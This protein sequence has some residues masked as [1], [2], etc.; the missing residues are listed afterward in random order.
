MNLEFLRKIVDIDSRSNQ[1]KGVNEV[2]KILG[3]TLSSLGFDAN[4][5]QNNLANTG[6]LLWAQLKGRT[7]RAI[8][9]VCHA[10]TVC[11]PSEK[12]KFKID[13]ANSRAYGPG[14]GDNKGGIALI[15]GALKDF[16]DISRKH[17][18]TINFICSPSE[19]IGSI[20]YHDF[21][22][23]RGIESDFVFGFEPALSNG[24]IITTRSGNRW[25]DIKIS[26]VSA[27]A[28]RWNENSINAAHIASEV[29]ANL[30]KLSSFELKRRVNVAQLFGG[31]DRFNVICGEMNIKLDT[32]FCDF[33]SREYIHE[34]ILKELECTKIIDP[35]NKIESNY[36]FSVA[37][38]CPPMGK[39]EMSDAFSDKILSSIFSFES[40]KVNK[41]YSGGAA[42]INYFQRPGLISIDGLGPVASKLHSNQEFIEIE[43]FYTRRQVFTELLL[44]L[45]NNFQEEKSGEYTLLNSSG[46]AKYSELT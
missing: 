10:D 7:S 41:A 5:L 30:S 45:N 29:V 24:D 21:F 6:E 12:C 33:D 11:G 36:S 3:E 18:Y 23:L 44:N 38:D 37:D 39:N 26:G 22:H 1:I 43:S 35:I 40:R 25:Y 27:H 13:F 8:T 34:T 28:G 46:I 20:G 19:E 16:L 17:F 15:I 42:D 2:Q 31:S 14:V 32:R 4:F 9:L